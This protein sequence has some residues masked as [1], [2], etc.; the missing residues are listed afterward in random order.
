MHAAGAKLDHNVI[1]ATSYFPVPSTP[2]EEFC[3]SPRF[4][5]RQVSYTS[6]LRVFLLKCGGESRGRKGVA[7]KMVRVP[8]ICSGT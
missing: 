3:F 4:P 5:Q 8:V 6:Q 2:I 1:N 7:S